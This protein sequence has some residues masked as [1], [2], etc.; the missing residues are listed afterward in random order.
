MENPLIGARGP[1][2]F[3]FVYSKA[4]A[5]SRVKRKW[6]LNTPTTRMPGTLTANPANS[7]W[8]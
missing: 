7:R 3:G 4:E 5:E 1:A 2:E 6:T 8:R